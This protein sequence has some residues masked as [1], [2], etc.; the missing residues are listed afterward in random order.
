MNFYIAAAILIVG[1]L[2]R[3]VPHVWNFTP[4]LALALFAGAY[5]PKR[6]MF[7]VPLVMMLLTDLILGFYPSIVVNWIAVL[8]SVAVGM[9]LR[10][11][12]SWMRLTACSFG[13]AVVFFLIS[14]LGVWLTDYPK[15][16]SGLADCYVLALPF[17]RTSLA[18]TLIYSYVLVGGYA[19][20]LRRASS[21]VLTE[22]A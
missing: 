14:N 6:L 15:T 4:V 5:L 22:K 1:F 19:W 10:E 3:L 2:S 21:R 7:A 13:A 20:M 17:F 8:A 9:L 16:W 18:S 12:N 11:K